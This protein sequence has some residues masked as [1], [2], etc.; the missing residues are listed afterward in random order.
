MRERCLNAPLG[1]VIQMR[2]SKTTSGRYQDFRVI[3]VRAQLPEAEPHWAPY[4]YT[5]VS[6]ELQRVCRVSVAEN[7]ATRTNGLAYSRKVAGTSIWSQHSKWKALACKGNAAD[8]TWPLPWPT[9]NSIPAQREMVKFHLAHAFELDLGMII[10][11]RTYYQRADDFEPHYY[12][13]VAH[14][15][16]EHVQG[17]T[18]TGSV[19]WP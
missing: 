4:D 6:L 15:S 5:T 12:G 14:V 13:G 16:H 9:G 10:S 8:L 7:P 3:K 19:C 2:S 11:E 17:A 1:T 18:Q